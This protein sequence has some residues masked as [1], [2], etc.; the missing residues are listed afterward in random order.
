MLTMLPSMEYAH[1]PAISLRVFHL[2]LLC[3]VGVEYS[4]HALGAS[5]DRFGQ[6]EGQDYK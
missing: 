6:K 4:S 3:G 2:V 5:R 1:V